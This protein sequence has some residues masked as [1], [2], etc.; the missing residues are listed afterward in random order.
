M[1]LTCGSRRSTF[2]GAKVI[3]DE[4]LDEGIPHKGMELLIERV[5][6]I[7]CA[8]DAAKAKRDKFSL[9]YKQVEAL[10]E[11]ER[12]TALQLCPTSLL[13]FIVHSDS[14][15]Q[16]F[17]LSKVM[18]WY[19]GRFRVRLPAAVFRSAGECAGQLGS[20]RKA[21]SFPM[22]SSSR[23]TSPAAVCLVAK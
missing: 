3:S 1:E 17:I 14:G 8:Y 22:L 10:V 2:F 13:F 4:F 9:V 16:D 6:G 11:G 23:G 12:M 19:W 15:G 5:S 21:S 20:A 18:S 7:Q